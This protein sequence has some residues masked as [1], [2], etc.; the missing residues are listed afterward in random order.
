MMF[1][2]DHFD[3]VQS[4]TKLTQRMSKLFSRLITS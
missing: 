2:R 1:S 3:V 4:P